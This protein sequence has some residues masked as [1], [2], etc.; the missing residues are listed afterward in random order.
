MILPSPLTC[1]RVK[2][3]W[4]C[5]YL[6]IFISLSEILIVGGKGP[7]THFHYL[8]DAVKNVVDERKANQTLYM[9]RDLLALMLK[10]ANEHS[11]TPEADTDFKGNFKKKMSFKEVNINYQYCQM[12]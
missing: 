4:D 3:N 5:M 9:E 2:L 8:S 6:S 12:K 10:Y 7:F 11:A 1:A